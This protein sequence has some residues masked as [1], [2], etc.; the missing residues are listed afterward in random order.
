MLDFPELA[1]CCALPSESDEL[2]PPQINLYPQLQISTIPR[3]QT[4]EQ[5]GYREAPHRHG[6][7]NIVSEKELC[8]QCARQVLT[9]MDGVTVCMLFETFLVPLYV[10]MYVIVPMDMA[11][12]TY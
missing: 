10:C 7:R 4:G 12:W 1:D 6:Y 2:Y 8:E 11:V 9:L 3:F 5:Q